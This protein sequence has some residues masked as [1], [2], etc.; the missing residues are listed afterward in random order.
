MNGYVQAGDG[1]EALGAF[2]QMQAEVVDDTVLVAL[3]VL[4]ACPQLGALE[5]EKWVHGY[6]KANNISL[7]VLLGT[8]FVDM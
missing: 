6:L 5:Q 8:A 1:R 7:S 4:A 2:S 3:G